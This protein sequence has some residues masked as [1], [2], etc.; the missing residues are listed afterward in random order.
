[1]KDELN[2]LKLVLM[3]TIKNSKTTEENKN[4]ATKALNVVHLEIRDIQSDG[5]RELII[6]YMF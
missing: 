5:F 3:R 4:L 6:K 2:K 1:M